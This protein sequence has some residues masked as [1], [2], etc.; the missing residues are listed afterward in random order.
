MNDDGIDDDFD[1]DVELSFC[2]TMKLLVWFGMVLYLMLCVFV[3]EDLK[4]Y[5]W[6][7]CVSVGMYWCLCVYVVWDETRDDDDAR[8]CAGSAMEMVR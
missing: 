1:D 4:N 7:G 6:C 8:T 3:L 2:V 5:G